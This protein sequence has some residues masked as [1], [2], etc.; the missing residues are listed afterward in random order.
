MR[1]DHLIAD[2]FAQTDVFVHDESI[3][4]KL[5][6]NYRADLM[7]D[8]LRLLNIIQNDK[9][10]SKKDRQNLRLATNP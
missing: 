3:V 1:H 6:R 7:D 9:G 4:N 2:L 8:V 10:C 5:L